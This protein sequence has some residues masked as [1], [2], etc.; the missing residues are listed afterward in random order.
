MVFEARWLLVTA[1]APVTLARRPVGDPLVRA[2]HQGK[3]ALWVAAGG[4]LLSLSETGCRSV[5]SMQTTSNSS[6]LISLRGLNSMNLWCETTSSVTSFEQMPTPRTFF[7]QTAE[8]KTNNI[9]ASVIFSHC[10]TDPLHADTVRNRTHV[11]KALFC[12][13]QRMPLQLLGSSDA[14]VS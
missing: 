1:K 8:L 6:N 11:E 13:S 4:C 2:S 9:N 5:P 14:L 10:I 12:L 7:F 3:S